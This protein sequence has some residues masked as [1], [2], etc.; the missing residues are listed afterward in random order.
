[1][2]M[3]MCRQTAALDTGRMH[4]RMQGNRPTRRA[5]CGSRMR[6]GRA[7]SKARPAMR[8]LLM[9]PKPAAP[10]PAPAAPTLPKLP[11][12]LPSSSP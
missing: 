10:A 6:A 12:P 1:M 11:G 3:C 8:L 7:R 4:A 9:W 5:R 2:C